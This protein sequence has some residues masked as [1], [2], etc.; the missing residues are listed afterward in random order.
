MHS[1]R[2]SSQPPARRVARTL[3]PT[4]R[5]ELADE[6]PGTAS[7]PLLEP[8]TVE[9]RPEQRGN[10]LLLAGNHAGLVWRD[11]G[12]NRRRV[13]CLRGE[14][15]MAGRPIRTRPVEEEGGAPAALLHSSCVGYLP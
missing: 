1:E 2:P 7:A 12:G 8:V 13:P 5:R 15:R 9:H 6:R 4:G 14:P 11:R 10:E 3:A